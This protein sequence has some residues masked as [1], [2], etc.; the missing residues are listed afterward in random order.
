MSDAAV[1]AADNNDLDVTISKALLKGNPNVGPA[2][3]PVDQMWS[4]VGSDEALERI[5]KFWNVQL[6]SGVSEARKL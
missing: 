1:E 5:E 3:N 4:R 2:S 6:Q